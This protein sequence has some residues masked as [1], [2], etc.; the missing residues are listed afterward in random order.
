[1]TKRFN[2][3]PCRTILLVL[4]TLA[5][6]AVIFTAAQHFTSSASGLPVS[7]PSGDAPK[8]LPN[9]D[10]RTDKL[11]SEKL[12][13]FR[14]TLNKSASQA[15]DLQAAM[16]RGED[17][18]R[19][20]VPTLKV[21]YNNELHNPEIIAP[22]PAKGSA[23]LSRGAGD[24][25][26]DILK[27]FLNRNAELIGAIGSQIDDLKV[28]A[29]YTNPDGNLSF[30]ELNQEINGIPVFRG[31][32]KAGFTKAGE[33][34]R[35]VNNLA[36]G[37]EYA[38]LSTD[39][40]DP[41]A[42]LNAATSFIG[43]DRLNLN[44]TP[45]RSA[46]DDL[47]TV[48]G[49]G[50][51][52][53]TAEKMYFPTEPGVAVPA[54]RVLIWQPVNVYYVIVDAKTG[55]M[56]WRKNIT[57]DQTQPG[58]YSVYANPNAM[59]NVAH[60]P[61]PFS[62]GPVAPNGMQGTGI[63]RSSVTRIG[64][65][66]PY[67]FNHL[68][69]IADGATRTDGNAVQAGIDRDGSDGVDPNSE[70]VSAERDFTFA[71]NPL[72]PNT[73][74]GDAPV[75]ALQTYPGTA[76]Q[77][78]SVTQLFYICNWFHDETYRLGFT[79]AARNFQNVNFT[80]QGLGGDRVRAEGQDSLTFN[81]AQFATPADGT[82]GRMQM[83]VWN[84]PNPDIDGSFDADVVVHEFTHGLSNR[85]I[86]NGGG[87]TNDMSRG[88][89]EG[90]SDFYGMSLLSQPGDPPDGLYTTGSYVTFRLGGSFINNS[91]YGIRRFPTAVKTSLGGPN[92]RAHNPLT[93]ADIDAT[94]LNLSD[95][96]FAP[97]TNGMADEVHNAGEVWSI[98]LWEIRARLIARLG[99]SE[100]NRK[101]LQFVTD[102][103]KLSPLSPTFVSGR[104]AIVAAGLASGTA[105][106]VADMWAGFAIRGLGATASVQNVGGNSNG[107]T[108]TVRVTESFSA[109]NLLQSP[110]F[111]VS[112]FLGNNNGAFEPGEI[113]TLSI[114]LTN[115]T[116]NTAAGVTLQ[117]V[118]GAAADYGT[119]THARTVTRP[120][121]FRVPDS[122]VCGSSQTI[123]F[124][125]NSSLGPISFT[126]S[127]A[128]GAPNVTFSQ[129]F[130]DVTPPSVPAGWTVAS[131]YAPM[132]FVST[133]VSADT[134]PISMFA[135]DLPD[136]TG[137]G[138]PTTNGGSTEL[139]SPF[140]FITAGSTGATV[141][142]RHKYN[143]ELG[144]DGG[145]L[146]ISV[147]G[148]Q[149]PFD[150]ITAVGGAFLQ[151][152]YTGALGVSAPNPL[153]GRNAWSGESAGYITTTARLPA[154]AAGQ[155]IKLRWRFG[156]DNNTAPV[157]GG[158]NVD[159]IQVVG[160]FLCF[161]AEPVRSRADF[162]GDGRSDLS[163]YRP[164]EGNW[165]LNRSSQGFT[166]VG[167]GLSDD[168][169][170]PGDFDGDRKTDIAVWR[171][172][173]GI[174]YRLNSG[175]G[176]F[177]S[178]QF[179]LTG[180]IP[181]PGDFDGDR[182]E[183]I[184]VFRP[185]NGTW[186]WQNSGD[187]QIGGFQ[188]GQNGDLPAGGDYDGD[189]KD[190]LTLFRPSTGLWFRKNSLGGEAETISF[191]LNGDLPVNADYDGDN[192]EDIAVF[193]PSNGNW[194]L[195][196]SGNSQ[197]AAVNF[198]LSGDVPVP[199]DYDGDGRDDIAVYRGGTWY[200]NRSTSGLVQFNF[201]L[202][203]DVPIPKKYIP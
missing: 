29:D 10:I 62:P 175:D 104:D 143:T 116:G 169:P 177:S 20:S 178:F 91:Y 67:T 134:A 111:G 76:Y 109:P 12:V 65:E 23:F 16:R 90:W 26:S 17:R 121:T 181:Q 44:L 125:V 144:F 89:G 33:L 41:V 199:G 110:Q 202:A 25:R 93:F 156:A 170:T 159:T 38:S 203:A 193:R 128:I 135:P 172:S 81:N 148:S 58:T 192:R 85:L 167:F 43:A 98:M 77:Q 48:F 132:T 108:G 11:A 113:I 176:T 146:E 57:E 166:G 123:T 180:D 142:F 35:V 75:P 45:N 126:G 160:S 106:D 68:G 49:S 14:A 117:V 8:A 63:P 141:S 19:Q 171:P 32:V 42:A 153:G 188:F 139:T 191:G 88:M 154:S 56:L 7:R 80:G 186:Y 115:Y 107:G 158:W 147:G 101:A 190:D 182:R 155:P 165:Y 174:W 138:C 36:P 102:G 24:R 194:Y 173:T 3:G 122:A 53:T 162:D 103:L 185:S 131:S 46:S 95:A 150:D 129:N 59:I 69:W 61:F 151:N 189:F 66:A 84:G 133:T 118:G 164:A 73:N 51:S 92:A 31:E 201:G 119:I 183:D 1:M 96:A 179:G 105:E 82:R 99:W 4:F 9:Y 198:G 64:N 28:F 137:S 187:G 40:G 70:A 18:L 195:L 34:I 149:A 97:R 163:V 52:A 78:G 22:D 168:I 130:D 197:F 196:N 87:M 86:G 124:A 94:Q 79:E 13:G 136:C 55:T 27:G 184:A 140:I 120:A 74:G 145:V 39:F 15:V 161:A 112:D 50:D 47:K 6:I 2:S 54:W 60:S 71:Y 21:E 127:I 30:V 157:G 152:G 100:G 37:L 200:L 114:P 83:Y 72:D 5:A